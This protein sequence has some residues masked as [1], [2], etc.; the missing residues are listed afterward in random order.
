MPA[1]D[2]ERPLKVHFF[3]DRHGETYQAYGK[4]HPYA[5]TI[6]KHNYPVQKTTT[7]PDEVTCKPC[8]RL[9][10]RQKA[11]PVEVPA[12]HLAEVY[13]DRDDLQDWLYSEMDM[14]DKMAALARLLL[15]RLGPDDQQVLIMPSFTVS[16]FALGQ[17]ALYD[18][19]KEARKGRWNEP[20]LGN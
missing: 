2:F 4:R 12:D 15:D 6:C 1:I 8:R 10:E 11:A 13:K 7:N 14:S 9:M 16:D 18:N 5:N 3:Q 19:L 17:L 20:P